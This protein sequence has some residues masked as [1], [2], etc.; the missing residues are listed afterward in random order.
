M[1]PYIANNNHDL[2]KQ[3]IYIKELTKYKC[4]SLLYDL[5]NPFYKIEIEIHKPHLIYD[6][7]Q[8]IFDLESKFN[9]IW[10][11]PLMPGGE[12]VIAKLNRDKNV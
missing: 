11:H 6:L 3:S 1:K 10:Y 8:R 12:G 7:E 5:N 2:E 4:K 9:D